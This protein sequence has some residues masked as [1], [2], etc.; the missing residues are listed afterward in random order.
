[1]LNLDAVWIY[2]MPSYWSLW[3]NVHG[4]FLVLALVT[5]FLCADIE[6]GPKAVT[7]RSN[8]E[9]LLK[10]KNTMNKLRMQWVGLRD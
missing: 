3:F 1:M 4:Q 8:Q 7:M 5:D 6:Y 2:P 9:E 10:L